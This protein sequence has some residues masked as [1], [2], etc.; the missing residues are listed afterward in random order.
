MKR[1]KAATAAR[2]HFST[3]GSDSGPINLCAVRSRSTEDVGGPSN[4]ISSLAIKPTAVRVRGVRGSARARRSLFF[5]TTYACRW[6][7]TFS[8]RNAMSWH[9]DCEA[10]RGPFVPTRPP[11]TSAAP[12]TH[13]IKPERTMATTEESMLAREALPPPLAPCTYICTRPCTRPSLP[14]PR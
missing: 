9:M 3:D 1:E 7:R 4:S 11:P 10:L 5:Q 13:S 6:V 12:P 8:T 14:T 2:M